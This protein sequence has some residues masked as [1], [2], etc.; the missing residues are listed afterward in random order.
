MFACRQDKEV[1]AL[2]S[3]DH[4]Y[5]ETDVRESLTVFVCLF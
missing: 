1:L 2:L 4:Y 5:R 3:S